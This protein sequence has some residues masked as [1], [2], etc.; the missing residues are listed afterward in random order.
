M[1]S[2]FAV[3]QNLLSRSVRPT[4]RGAT[5]VEYALITAIIMVAILVALRV[6]GTQL[7]VVFTT[8]AT[9]VGNAL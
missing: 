2:V 3:L 5:A 4:D 1:Y 7:K 6:L 8:V 9:D